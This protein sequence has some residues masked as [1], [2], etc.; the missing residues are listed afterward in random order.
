MKPPSASNSRMVSVFFYGLF[1]D[2]DMLRSKGFHPANERQASVAGMALRLGQ[3]AALALDPSKSAYGFVMDLSQ[4]EL[5][6]LY[7]D[8][9][10][11]A[12][13]PE[14]V[15]A[16]LTSGADIAALCY[17]LP[18]PPRPDERNPAYA[19]KLREVGRRL[20]LPHQYVES[21]M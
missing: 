10:V 21:I 13:R 1:M 6:L 20:G 9:S 14:A 5:D 18:M 3:R 15:T 17:N 11:A 19:A 4:E 16:P 12:Y 8:P 7:S 2:A